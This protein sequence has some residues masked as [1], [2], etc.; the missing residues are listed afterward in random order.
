[1]LLAFWCSL[2]IL[3]SIFTCSH[4]VVLTSTD[5]T[6][7]RFVCIW[8]AE[9]T[10][11]SL[12]P[13]LVYAVWFFSQPFGSI[14]CVLY[15]SETQSSFRCHGSYIA[16]AKSFA[17]V[18]CEC[19][20]ARSSSCRFFF[21]Y[22]FFPIVTFVCLWHFHIYVVMVCVRARVCV[23]VKSVYLNWN[24]MRCTYGASANSSHRISMQKLHWT[25]E[26]C[27]EKKRNR[28]PALRL[29]RAV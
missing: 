17:W 6:I 20:R 25:A 15:F 5:S 1:M 21:L 24:F 26:Y 2:W 23:Q 16:L 19:V 18:V 3:W 10:F 28:R 27:N 29:L 7:R 11:R 14:S 22:C 4:F 13:T 12:C 9:Q 8:Q